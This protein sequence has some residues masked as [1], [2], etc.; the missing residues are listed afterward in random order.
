MTGLLTGTVAKNRPWAFLISIGVVFGLYTV[1]PQMAKFGLVFFQHLTITPVFKESLPNILPVS[2]GVAV[3]I[4]QHLM[5]SVKFF[6]L[7]FS[8]SVFTLFSQGGLILTFL[9]MLCRKW[10]CNEAH[11]LGKRWAGGLFLWV[12]IPLVGLAA[13]HLP[14]GHRPLGARPSATRV[15]SYCVSFKLSHLAS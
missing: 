12:H 6:H 7:E 10:R 5:P 15:S 2:A 9:V 1:I 13:A 4:S 3:S 14:P 11:L 8:E